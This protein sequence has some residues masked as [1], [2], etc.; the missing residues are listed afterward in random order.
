MKREFLKNLGL[1]DENIDKIMTELGK[2]VNADK[3][4]LSDLEEKL[5]S[6]NESIETYKTKISELESVKE[7]STK[8]QEELDKIKSEIAQKEAEEKAKKDDEILTNNIIASFGDKQF[9]NE[10]TKNSIIN[11]IKVAL[12][13]VNNAGKSSKDLFEE[14]TK[15]KSDIFTNPNPIN[16]DMAGMGDTTENNTIKE[17]PQIW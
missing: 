2:E 12:K 4:K 6:A 3:T 9:V 5:N 10:Y 11:D 7:D 17:M 14:I 1:E 13:D 15:D 8:V 16:N